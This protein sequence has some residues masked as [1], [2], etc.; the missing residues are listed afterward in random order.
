MSLLDS[1]RRGW[2]SGWAE[3]P[4]L[5]AGGAGLLESLIPGDRPDDPLER[6]KDWGN[7]AA[8]GLRLEGGGGTSEGLLEKITEGLGAAPGTLAS[9]APFMWGG[10]AVAGGRMAAK[11]LGGRILGPALGFGAHSAVRHGDEGL[12]SAIGHGLKGAAEGAVFGGLGAWAGGK[13]VSPAAERLL[14]KR[15]AMLA[16]GGDMQLMKAKVYQGLAEEAGLN[17]LSSQFKRKA[18]HGAS[19]GGFVGGMTGIHGG[20]LEESVAAGTTIGLLGLLSRGKYHEPGW[21]TERKLAEMRPE[22]EAYAKE[23]EAK[24]AKAGVEPEVTAAKPGEPISPE[25]VARESAPYE[26]DVRTEAFK[27]M[28]DRLEPEAQRE[29]ARNQVEQGPHSVDMV[30]RAAQRMGIDDQGRQLAE[31]SDWHVLRFGD[32]L[33]TIWR[34]KVNLTRQKLLAEKEGNAETASIIQQ[35]IE[36]L[37]LKE[38]AVFEPLMGTGTTGGRILRAMRT[39]KENTPEWVEVERQLEKSLGPNVFKQVKSLAVLSEGNPELLSRISRAVNTPKMWDYMMEYWINGLLSGPT[40]QAVNVSSNALRQ[41][42]DHVE[43][44]VGLHVEI[45]RSAKDPKG[46]K[47]EHSDVAM[48]MGAD[49]RAAID[50]IRQLPKFL[51]ATFSEARRNELI[52][53]DVHM[54]MYAERTKLDHP[55]AAIPGKLGSFIRIPGNMLQV[56]DLYFKGIAGQRAAAYTSTRMAYEAFRNKEIKATE[57]EGRI[58][59]LMGELPP[60]ERLYHGS[61][62]IGLAGLRE[63]R[64]EHQR[65]AGIYLTR[66]QNVA[67][68]YTKIEGKKSNDRLYEVIADIK[69]PAPREVLDEIG[70]GLGGNKMREELIRRGYDGVDDSLMDEIVAFSQD[71]VRIVPKGSRRGE[72]HPDILAAMK[73]EAEIQTFT[74]RIT[75]PAGRLVAGLREVPVRIPILGFEAKPG[76]LVIPFWQTPWNVVMQSIARSPIGLLRWGSLKRRYESRELTPQEYYKE[77]T[78]TVMGTAVWGALLTVAKMGGLTGG[79]P[80]NY[81]D[82]Q[83]LLATGW[84]PYS[85]KIGDAYIQMQRLEPLGT[86][87]GLAADAAEFGASDDKTSKAIAIVKDN[88]TDKSFLYGLESFAKAF[89]NPE[90]AGS[91]YYRQMAGSIVPTFFSKVAQA[92]DPYQRVQEPLGAAAGVPDALAYRIP[93]V[94]RALPARTTA[95][96]EKAERWGV[97]STES[98]LALGASAVQS[99]FNP[100]GVSAGRLNTEVEREFDR[101]RGYEGMPPAMPKRTKRIGIRG[102]D[103]ENIKLTNEEYAVYDKYHARAKQAL[104]RVISSARWESIPDVMKAKMLRSTY[105]KYRSAAN[106]EINTMIRRRTTVGN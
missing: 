26:S 41:G 85:I 56:M 75:H 33:N 57:I 16:H 88:M 17:T 105:G 62:T 80:A 37:A 20:D 44:T 21:K 72:P 103:G 53:N 38:A 34:D 8:R 7:Q 89:A 74:E 71:Q 36:A 73:K 19:V 54:K 64:G 97:M 11:T 40:T 65:V 81:S 46:T 18:L 35:R 83:N 59:E 63:G 60:G 24:R 29:L 100:L 51:R 95:L 14:S 10:G 101:L 92:V 90:Q 3:F 49:F 96:G 68:K 70:Y 87:L 4:E 52:D 23:V 48:I 66:D 77:V 1:L 50:G 58:A 12:P 94:S 42:V 2:W 27:E 5:V 78:A 67:L 69:N 79:G 84:R 39:V 93:F 25:Q 22:A 102:V 86:V 28:W 82:R 106:K 32:K 61:S 76:T 6:L 55:T 47:L 104:S 13:F 43:K 98:P 30:R 31:A 9:M 99:V 15:Q 45:A 91:I